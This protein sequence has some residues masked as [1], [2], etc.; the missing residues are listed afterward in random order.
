MSL[1]S[2]ANILDIADHRF[3]FRSFLNSNAL[4]I[5]QSIFANIVWRE[6]ITK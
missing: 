6:R 1:L 2:R 4:P 3:I 5:A